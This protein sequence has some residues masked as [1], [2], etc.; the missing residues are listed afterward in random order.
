MRELKFRAWAG[1]ILGMLYQEDKMS[2]NI[3]FKQKKVLICKNQ[4]DYIGSGFENIPLMQFT[5]LQDKNGVDIYEGD[6]LHWTSFKED[7]EGNN[8]VYN[9]VV[10]F[11]EGVNYVGYRLRNKSYTKRL[12]GRAGIRNAK[13]IVIGNIHQNP[14][15]LS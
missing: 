5:G 15:L 3:D 9:N 7:S 13:A 2:F 1:T 4:N 10:E 14:E 6:I 8:L 11:Y 12:T